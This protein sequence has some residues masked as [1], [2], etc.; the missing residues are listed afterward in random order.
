MRKYFTDLKQKTPQAIAP[1]IVA[2]L[3]F[4]IT[5]FCFGAANS[6]IAP[7]AT[8]SYLGFRNMKDNLGC[9]VRHYLIYLVMTLAAFAAMSGLALCILINAAALFWIAYLL[10]NE[11]Q[12][13]NYFPAGMALILPCPIQGAPTP[14]QAFSSQELTTLRAFFMTMKRAWTLTALFP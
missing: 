1:T 5:Y 3:I 2:A 6:M 8:L 4:L 10:I 11:Y 7:F 12:P 14:P 9:M 13:T